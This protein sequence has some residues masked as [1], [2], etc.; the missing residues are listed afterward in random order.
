MQEN[1]FTDEGG[2]AHLLS[3]DLMTSQVYNPSSLQASSWLSTRQSQSLNEHR[4]QLTKDAGQ[5]SD[6]NEQKGDAAGLG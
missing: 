2:A 5:V 6:R 3:R 1:M 4:E